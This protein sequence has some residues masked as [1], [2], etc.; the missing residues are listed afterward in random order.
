MSKGLLLL[1]LLL[2]LTLYAKTFITT[3]SSCD[4]G[5]N[6]TKC[7]EVV[8]L[9]FSIDTNKKQVFV[10]GKD[11]TGKD[12]KE[13]IDKCQINDANNWV[14]ESAQLVTDVKNGVITIKNK[15]ESSMAKNKKEV[16][17][18]K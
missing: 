2:P 17:L 9:T 12:M 16:C 8:K 14:C 5:S 7:Y 3:L 4:M 6:C 11:A 10:S 15:P 1:T 13:L 18:I